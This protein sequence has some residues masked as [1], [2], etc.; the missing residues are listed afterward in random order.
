MIRI[1]VNYG[2]LD[3]AHNAD[4]GNS[5]GD[6]DFVVLCHLEHIRSP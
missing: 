6:A 4:D 5:V 3:N 1:D 2:N